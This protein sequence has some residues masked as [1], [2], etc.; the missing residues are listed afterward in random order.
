MASA[1]HRL[2][3][4]SAVAAWPMTSTPALVAMNSAASRPA[5]GPPR[6]AVK[7]HT[8]STHRAAARA[9][10]RRSTHSLRPKADT[11]AACSQ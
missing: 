3:T 7:R 1:S 8:A 11:L 4:A 9:E 5:T 2:S 10:G 6:A